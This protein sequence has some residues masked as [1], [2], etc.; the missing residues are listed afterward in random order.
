MGYQLKRMDSQ[1]R[2]SLESGMIPGRKRPAL[3]VQEG[4]HTTILAYFWDEEDERKFWI[5]LAWLIGKEIEKEVSGG[6]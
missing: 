3:Y 5:S 4:S 2:I 1:L 6:D